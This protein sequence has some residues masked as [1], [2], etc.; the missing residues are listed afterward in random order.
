MAASR[1]RTV[2][3]TIGG[4]LAR[5]DLPAL[6]ERACALLDSDGF[7][8]LR[9][10]VKGLVADAVAVDTLARLALAARRR[11]GSVLLCD[12]SPELLLLLALVGLAEV[13]REGS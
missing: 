2:T 9:C 13:L 4:Q 10:E 5:A 6:H 3:L 1:R 8:V 7:D 12:A 11:G